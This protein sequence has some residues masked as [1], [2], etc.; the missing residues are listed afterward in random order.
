MVLHAPPA[1]RKAAPKPRR[2]T[3]DGEFDASAYHRR[4][5]LPRSVELGQGGEGT[6]NQADCIAA[7][8][9]TSSSRTASSGEEQ[10]AI[11]EASGDH[12]PDFNPRGCRRACLRDL[13]Y[14]ATHQPDEARRRAAPASGS[15]S[16]GRSANDDRRQGPRVATTTGPA[17]IVYDTGTTNIDFGPG[18]PAQFRLRADGTTSLDEWASVGA[19]P[20]ARSRRGLVQYRRQWT[21]TATPTIS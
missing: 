4:S 9:S 1:T 11:Y 10:N 19:R 8:T 2:L 13:M 15:A 14:D 16:R 6:C 5:H 7:C 3:A 12:L 17:S 18:T 21:T 20:W